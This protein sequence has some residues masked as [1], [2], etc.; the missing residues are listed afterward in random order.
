MKANLKKSIALILV[1]ALLGCAALVNVSAISVDTENKY[2]YDE[3]IIPKVFQDY[4]LENPDL[5]I[6]YNEV[7]EYY[8]HDTDSSQDESIPEYVLIY[9]NSNMCMD[10]PVG[11]VF[12]DYVLMNSSGGYPYAYGYGI[13][14]PSTEEIYDLSVAYKMGIEG[15]ESVFTEVK[16][17]KLIGDMDKDREITIKDAT[18]IQKCLSGI[19]E[20]DK[21][22]YIIAF[23][24][25]DNPPLLYVSDF[26]RDCKRNISDA[27]AIQKYLAEIDL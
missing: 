15:I 2:K 19:S 25:E 18:I 26:N 4:E 21:N 5:V 11:D 9:L 10:M 13:F 17:G 24:Y 7:F 22:D 14:I 8:A 12:G 1:M 23:S 27:T 16:I 6:Y 3:I 20:F